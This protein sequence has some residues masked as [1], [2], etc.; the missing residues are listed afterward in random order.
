MVCHATTLLL[1]GLWCILSATVVEYK[2]YSLMGEVFA[3]YSSMFMKDVT[4]SDYTDF[5]MNL[6][7]SL[8][9]RMVLQFFCCKSNHDRCQ[10][11]FLCFIFSAQSNTNKRENPCPLLKLLSA[12]SSLFLAMITKRGHKHISSCILF[13]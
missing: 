11:C 2:G 12:N 3:I 9:L 4:C 5:C 6:V 7:L 10:G 8:K 13:T 1:Y